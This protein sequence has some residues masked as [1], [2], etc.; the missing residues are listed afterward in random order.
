MRRYLVI[1]F[2]LLAILLGCS[3]AFSAP[4]PSLKKDGNKYIIGVVIPECT[5]KSPE[6]IFEFFRNFVVLRWA[7]RSVPKEYDLVSNNSFWVYKK[8]IKTWVSNYIELN[9]HLI[10]RGNRVEGFDML[11]FFYKERQE[12]KKIEDEIGD[13]IKKYFL[14]MV[15]IKGDSLEYKKIAKKDI[16]GFFDYLIADAAKK[17][18]WNELVDPGELRVLVSL[19]ES[20]FP[21]AFTE[22]S[23]KIFVGFDIDTAR[24]IAESMRVKF[25]IISVEGTFD[26]IINKLVNRQGDIAF[27][28]SKSKDRLNKVLLIPYFKI[29]RVL[30][31][32]NV[33]GKRE[34][35]LKKLNT[36]GAVIYTRDG[37]VYTEIAKEMFPLA[38]KNLFTG[39]LKAHYNDITKYDTSI[40][41]A[42]LTNKVRL[43]DAN[44]RANVLKLENEYLCVAIRP[45]CH[46]LKQIINENIKTDIRYKQLINRYMY[47]YLN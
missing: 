6:Y 44:I 26:D 8:I 31:V 45:D 24:L 21:F 22:K 27:F 30:I 42:V 10:R 35:I 36:S 38:K 40:M 41:M 12:I 25:S 33:F 37:S 4:Y 32:C 43:D 9:E 11:I 28:I 17:G 20:I 18:V 46:L 2:I 19:N 23:K 29:R 34:I 7:V 14:K 1:N 15:D 13:K 16:E 3:A 47:Y 39:P 5:I